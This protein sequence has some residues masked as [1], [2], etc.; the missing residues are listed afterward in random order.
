MAKF[1]SF[2]RRIFT[3]LLSEDE[4][5]SSTDARKNIVLIPPLPSSS[6]NNSSNIQTT[7]SC[8]ASPRLL[9]KQTTI[10]HDNHR[11]RTQINF[12]PRSTN[13]R[14]S[15]PLIIH[16]SIH[17]RQQRSNIVDG[18]TEETTEPPVQRLSLSSTTGTTS[19]CH[20]SSVHSLGTSA[21][22]SASTSPRHDMH[23]SSL[24]LSPSNSINIPNSLNNF[25]PA[26]GR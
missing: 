1:T 9:T 26:S 18:T 16:T 24:N 2:F 8:S 3:S 15:A 5:S 12:M 14:L 13:R 22:D 23:F 10:Q 4:C 20:N 6:N 21:A 11:V 19:V 17:P 7:R 25:S